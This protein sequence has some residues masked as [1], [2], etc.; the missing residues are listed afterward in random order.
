MIDK[1]NFFFSGNKQRVK[2]IPIIRR[3]SGKDEIANHRASIHRQ[4]SI[5]IYIFFFFGVKWRSV[6]EFSHSLRFHTRKSLTDERVKLFY[7]YFWWNGNFI[8]ILK[9]KPILTLFILTLSSFKWTQK[10]LNKNKL[11]FFFLWL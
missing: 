11:V 3:R 10:K 7:Y 9:R 1:F 6:F 2:H 4:R 8:K 5:Y